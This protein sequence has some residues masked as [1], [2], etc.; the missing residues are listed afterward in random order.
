[1]GNFIFK[2]HYAHSKQVEAVDD[3][4]RPQVT[5]KPRARTDFLLMSGMAIGKPISYSIEVGIIQG[6][7]GGYAK[8]KSNFASKDGNSELGENLA[9]FDSGYSNIGRTSIGAGL[10]F[11]IATPLYLKAGAGYGSQF[12]EWKTT[13]GNIVAITEYSFAGVEPEVGLVL[14]ASHFVF[15]AGVSALIGKQ[16]VMDANVSVGVIF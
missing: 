4:P 15:G 3:K 9:F 12:T 7:F 13:D 2:V 10:L 5:D 11:R 8:Y 6:G 14:K 1:M 16:T